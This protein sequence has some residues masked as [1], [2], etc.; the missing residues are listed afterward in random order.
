[1][2]RNLS[3]ILIVLLIVGC[4]TVPYTGRSQLILVSEG[5]EAALGDDAYRHTLRESVVT[6]D[7]NAERIVRRVGDKIAAVA[8]KPEYK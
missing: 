1:M 8:N 6:R 5:Q 3:V 4:A 2:Q 7:V